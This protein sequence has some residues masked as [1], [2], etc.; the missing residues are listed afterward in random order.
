MQLKSKAERKTEHIR[1]ATTSQN[2]LSGL[3]V[4]T[5]ATSNVVGTFDGASGGVEVTSEAGRG[6]ISAIRG[7]EGGFYHKL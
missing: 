6:V 3:K 7:R 2:L 4:E 1:D 5:S